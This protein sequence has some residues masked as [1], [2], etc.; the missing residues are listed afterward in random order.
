MCVFHRCQDPISLFNEYCI[1]PFSSP[2]KLCEPT[3]N[4]IEFSKLI[5]GR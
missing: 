2:F 5:R 1:E 3:T 4:N